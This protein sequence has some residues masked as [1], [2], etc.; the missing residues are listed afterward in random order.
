M[1]SMSDSVWVCTTV[2]NKFSPDA[3]AVGIWEGWSVLN[4]P[5]QYDDGVGLDSAQRGATRF[6]VAFFK[7]LW[8]VSY[9]VLHK[10]NFSK[11]NNGCARTVLWEG[12]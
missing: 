3:H 9:L 7:S 6:L 2:S 10:S 4:A 12:D 5:F 8:R 1:L 11:K